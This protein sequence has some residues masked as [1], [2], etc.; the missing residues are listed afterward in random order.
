MT[1]TIEPLTEISVAR[2]ALN[3]RE[4]DADEIFATRWSYDP[5]D[6]ARQIVQLAT[7]GFVACLDRDPVAVVAA[8]P[9][10]PTTMAVGMFATSLWPKVALSTT[11]FARRLIQ[12]SVTEGQIHRAECRSI[13]GHQQAHDWL[14]LLGAVR[15]AELPDMGRNRE[16]FFLYAWRRRDFE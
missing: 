11:R 3:M 7:I 6:L 13:S 9:I 14:E 5:L 16:T 4:A 12:A 8:T 15:E 1:V 10:A 2:V